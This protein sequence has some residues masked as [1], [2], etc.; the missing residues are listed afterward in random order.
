MFSYCTDKL[1]AYAIHYVEKR[2]A[3]IL[4]NSRT[5]AVRLFTLSNLSGARLY[6]LASKTYHTS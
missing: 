6:N 2:V 4:E 3:W 5:T 1:Y